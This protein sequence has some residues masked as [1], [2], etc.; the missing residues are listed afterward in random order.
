L[1]PGLERLDDVALDD[2]VLQEQPSLINEERLEDVA[3]LRIP[4]DGVR[5]MQDIE[6]QRLQH[7]WVLVHPLKIEALESREGDG[8]L[9][10]VEDEIELPACGPLGE[11]VGETA[12]K[13]IRQNSERAKA[14]LDFVQIFDLLIK[15]ALLSGT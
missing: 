8:V 10:V 7:F 15:I 11:A 3:D 12:V 4:N 5:A 1:A 14:W 13:C 2:R 6:E 9:G